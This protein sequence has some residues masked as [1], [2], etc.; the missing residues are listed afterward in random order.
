MVRSPSSRSC[1]ARLPTSEAPGGV[2]DFL[3]SFV[4]LLAWNAFSSTLSRATTSLV[5]NS[6]LASK[7]YFPRL[8]LPLSGVFATL[9]D[10]GV[11]FGMLLVLLRAGEG[12]RPSPLAPLAPGEAV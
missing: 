12:Q 5:S 7:V 4:G 1:S 8:I 11:A 10:F 2:P 6:H 3:F 9:I